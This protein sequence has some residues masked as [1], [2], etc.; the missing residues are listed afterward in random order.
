LEHAT[1]QKK[2]LS[3]VFN[4]TSP[5]RPSTRS[6]RRP[7]TP[8]EICIFWLFLAAARSQPPSPAARDPVLPSA[9][10]ERALGQLHHAFKR[11]QKTPS[12]RVSQGQTLFGQKP[13][14][15]LRSV[16]LNLG[17]VRCCE[18]GVCVSRVGTRHGDFA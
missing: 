18:R 5:L 14:L 9:R 10:A 11:D 12:P 17:E 13:S 7:T 16:F 4:R 6:I 1:K 3:H 15:F 2:A 8:R